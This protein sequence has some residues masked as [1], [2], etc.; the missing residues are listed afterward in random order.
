[1]QGFSQI[2][3]VIN[4]SFEDLYYHDSLSS[5][6]FNIMKDWHG[7]DTFDIQLNPIV[8]YTYPN[9]FNH[10]HLPIP[11]VSWGGGGVYQYPR[12]GQ[13]VTVLTAYYE[14]LRDYA[15]GQIAEK[16]V[17][18]KTY[19]ISFYCNLAKPIVE[20]IANNHICAYVG[21][22][23]LDT[24][25]SSNGKVINYFTPQITCNNVVSDTMNWT[26]EEASFVATGNE[27]RIILG[28]FYNNYQ[29]TVMILDTPTVLGFGKL[30]EYF[31]DDISVVESAA[32]IIAGND[33][34]INQGD[35]VVLG[36]GI[37]EGLPCDWFTL[38]GT[39]V[40]RGS[41]PEVTPTTTTT[42]VVKMDL[43][44]NVTYD[45]M[46]VYVIPTGMQQFANGKEQLTVYPNP[47]NQ[48]IVIRQQSLVKTIEVYDV[49]G[50][51]VFNQPLNNSINHQIILDVANLPNG[52]YFLK[53]TDE[54][55]FQQIAKFIKE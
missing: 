25:L 50:Q 12:T 34:T 8:L 33:T 19:C 23:S 44:G 15:V 52:I 20:G 48:S 42:Y 53:V 24:I 36:K 21:G 18:G 47:A 26:K 30:S 7:T 2:N 37:T 3:H 17:A 45:T 31:I 43:C 55:G 16:L 11:A 4:P 35:T 39:P 5:P 41:M 51:I 22:N 38:N 28:N 13:V 14:Q 32:K 29:T 1:M 27:T 9:Q 40:Y 6:Y 10:N 49:L 54:Q 46:T